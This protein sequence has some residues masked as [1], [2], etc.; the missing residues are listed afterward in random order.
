MMKNTCFKAAGKTGAARDGGVITALGAGARTG[1]GGAGERVTGSAFAP[2]ITG[3]GFLYGFPDNL[4]HVGYTPLQQAFKGFIG[5][6][7]YAEKLICFDVKGFGEALQHIGGRKRLAGLN[8]GDIVGGHI[9]FFRKLFLGYALLPAVFLQIGR[10]DFPDIFTALQQT[11]L[12]GNFIL[13]SPS[14]LMTVNI[15]MIDLLLHFLVKP[16]GSWAVVQRKPPVPAPLA[17][18]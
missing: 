13:F 18:S 5:F 6:L 7:R 16:Y 10:Q 17:S 3:E 4:L 2:A 12:Y 9:G 8:H 14:G 11:Y 15:I 1:S